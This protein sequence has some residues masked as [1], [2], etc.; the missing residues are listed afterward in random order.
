MNDNKCP[1]YK[2]PDRI[3]GGEISCHSICDRYKEWRKAYDEWKALTDA[4]RAKY[5][6]MEGYITDRK[7]KMFKKYGRKV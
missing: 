6:S 5:S 7:Y 3:T 4:E 2:C 1:C